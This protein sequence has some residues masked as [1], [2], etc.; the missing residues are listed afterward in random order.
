MIIQTNSEILAFGVAVKKGNV[1]YKSFKV[2]LSNLSHARLLIFLAFDV[3]KSW[4]W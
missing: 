2:S 4:L 1:A 3:N